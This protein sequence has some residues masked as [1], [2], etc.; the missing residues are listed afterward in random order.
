M[1]S[2][3]KAE[4]IQFRVDLFA[5]PKVTR[6]VELVSKTIGSY[7]LAAS[8]DDLFSS[9]TPRVTCP[10]TS[11]VTRHA[12]RDVTVSALVRVWGAANAF[13]VDEVVPHVGL[14]WVDDQAGIPGFGKAMTKIGWLEALPD[15]GLR[16]PNFLEHNTPKTSALRSSDALRKERQRLRQWLADHGPEHPD[17]HAK[18]SR[19]AAIESR[20]M[21][22]DG[23]TLDKI[24]EEDKEER[25]RTPPVRDRP[26]GFP[27][28]ESVARSIAVGIGV[29]PD[30]AAAVW[31]EIEGRGGIDDRGN[32][33][34]NFASHVKA[35]A[36]YRQSRQ[37][38]Q[39]PRPSQAPGNSQTPD[40]SKAAYAR[41]MQMQEEAA[42]LR[43]AQFSG[44]DQEAKI[45]S[46]QRR[47]AELERKITELETLHD[48]KPPAPTRR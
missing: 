16:F 9:V 7:I 21:S 15:S 48:F 36:T 10:V 3:S 4:W 40:S 14:E 34:V 39:A 29:D 22:R 11:I 13:I 27:G 6:L 35:R 2:P 25:E 37:I 44:P 1:A 24:R 31:N 20:D 46:A 42:S 26:S 38:Q 28:S 43:K 33:I 41:Y 23:H 32:P 18:E 12:L 30:F 47:L 19:L 5:H 8:P 17:R 45:Q